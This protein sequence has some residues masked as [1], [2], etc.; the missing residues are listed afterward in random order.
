MEA[1]AFSTS[2]CGGALRV[3]TWFGECV[4]GV[5]DDEDEE[6]LRAACRAGCRWF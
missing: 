3:G 4:G 6:M 2:L 5:R 1:G